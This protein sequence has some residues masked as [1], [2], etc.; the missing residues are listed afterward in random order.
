MYGRSVLRP[1][2]QRAH[3]RYVAVAQQQARMGCQMFEIEILCRGGA[4]GHGRRER[5]D[6]QQ[7]FHYGVCVYRK[8][9]RDFFHDKNSAFFINGQIARLHRH[10]WQWNGGRRV[11]Y[12]DYN[13]MITCGSGRKR[14]P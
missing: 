9:H 11:P 1:R 6:G 5:Y 3:G 8:F 2:G 4:Y 14:V 13:Y 7:S 12:Y 10:V